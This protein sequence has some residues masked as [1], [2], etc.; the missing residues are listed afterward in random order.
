MM[1]KALLVVIG[2]ISL[3][4]MLSTVEARRNC[5][6]PKCPPKCE[7]VCPPVEICCEPAKE[8]CGVLCRAVKTHKYV[9]QPDKCCK[10]NVPCP[11]KE[12]TRCVP[13]PDRVEIEWYC[14]EICVPQPDKV[15]KVWKKKEICVPQP[16]R[17]ETYYECQPDTCC[18]EMVPCPPKCVECIEYVPFDLNVKQ[19][20]TEPTP[21]C[22]RTERTGSSSSCSRSVNNDM[23]N[24][25]DMK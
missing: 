16:D 15:E 7:K 17:V 5:H 6:K 23:D 4:S 22:E 13:Q 25:M 11:A 9:P 20:C 3:A 14:E 12:C 21:S 10:R 1:R 2:G 8:I 19:P 18:E 24:D